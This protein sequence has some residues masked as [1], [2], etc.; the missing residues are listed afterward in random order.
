MFQLERL[1]SF[2]TV[3]TLDDSK[4]RATNHLAQ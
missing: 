2:D 4:A 3:A 1:A